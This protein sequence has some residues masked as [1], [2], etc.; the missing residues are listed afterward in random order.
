[1]S[2]PHHIG[3]QPKLLPG[4]N[5][6]IQIAEIPILQSPKITGQ[7]VK[8]VITQPSKTQPYVKEK[9]KRNFLQQLIK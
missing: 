8:Q 9:P 1:M 5:P 3:V 2:Q 7:K 6:I 4:R